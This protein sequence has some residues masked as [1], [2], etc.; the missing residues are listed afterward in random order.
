MLNYQPQ[1]AGKYQLLVSTEKNPCTLTDFN[2]RETGII[3][4]WYFRVDHQKVDYLLSVDQHFSSRWCEKSLRMLEIP[5]E[6]C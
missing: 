2:I 4:C 1:E 3:K 6:Q 5:P